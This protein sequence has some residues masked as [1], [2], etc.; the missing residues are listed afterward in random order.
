MTKA[1]SIKEELFYIV[2]IK[3]K[4]LNIRVTFL[5]V[6]LLANPIKDGGIGNFGSTV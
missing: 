5:M 2:S 6:A 4:I 3:Q 1:T